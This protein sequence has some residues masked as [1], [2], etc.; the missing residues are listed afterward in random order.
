[1]GLKVSELSGRRTDKVS[2]VS[3]GDM[4]HFWRYSC[5]DDAL[6]SVSSESRAKKLHN[7]ASED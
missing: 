6:R 1:M 3:E 4:K 7:K 5:K 2:N